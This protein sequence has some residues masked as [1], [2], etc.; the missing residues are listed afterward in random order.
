MNEII[1]KILNKH[2]SQPHSMK[3]HGVSVEIEQA[4]KKIN[5]SGRNM[6][7]MGR[8]DERAKFKNKEKL[9][10]FI[11]Y[12]IEH[13]DERFWQALRNWSNQEFIISKNETDINGDYKEE[14]T[15]YWD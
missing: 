11:A 15:F 4:I 14:D 7:E 9:L 1:E 5:N 8:K 6:Y 10:D 12:C 13:E 3:H 2:Y